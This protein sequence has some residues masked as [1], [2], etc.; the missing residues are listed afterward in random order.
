MTVNVT[1]VADA[2]PDSATTLENNPVTVDV[3]EN[4]TYEDGTTVNVTDVSQPEH[5]EAV[6]NPDNTVTYNPSPGYFG[7]D[8]FEYTSTVTNADGST[9]TE[10]TTVTIIVDKEPDAPVVNVFQPDCD[11]ALGIIE[12]Q[13]IAGYTYNINGGDF[14]EG[15]S[16]EDLAAGIYEIRSMDPN[17]YISPITRVEIIQQ[18]ATP[19]APQVEEILEATCTDPTATVILAFNADLEYYLETSNGDII[20]D[21]DN[22]AIFENLPAGEYNI[23]A[24]SNSGCISEATPLSLEQPD[25]TIIESSN[26]ELCSGDTTFDLFDLLSGEYDETGTWI[27]TEGT[28]ALSGNSIEPS[29]LENGSYKFTYQLDDTCSTSTEVIITINDDCIVLPCSIMDIKN[30]ISKTV[31]PNGDNHND[32]FMID[33]DVECEFIYDVMIFNRWGAKVFEAKNYQNN[34]D[35]QSQNSFTQSNQLPAGTYYYFVKMRGSDMET[36]QGYIYLGTK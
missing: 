6:I 12:V 26:I 28:G 21:E 30:S 7:T 15:G 36:I 14:K 33:K 2:V 8:V 27:D 29:L 24:R 23:F 20:T 5:G 1:P 34:W 9:T 31:T 22:D 25:S 13:S 3:L 32:F 10:T 4:D 35:G 19:S 11:T 16:F 17:G 18:P